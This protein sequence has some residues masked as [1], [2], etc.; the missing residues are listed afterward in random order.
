MWGKGREG[1]IGVD[2]GGGHSLSPDERHERARTQG[3]LEGNSVGQREREGLIGVGG[4]E[5]ITDI[6]GQIKT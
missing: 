6:V 5:W 4:W 2:G 3:R 1:L